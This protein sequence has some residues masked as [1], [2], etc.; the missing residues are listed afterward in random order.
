MVNIYILQLQRNKYYIGKTTNPNFRLDQHFNNQGSAWTKKY[1]PQ[2]IIK[3]IPNCSHYDEDKYTQI[4]M[5]KYGIYNVRGGS[6]CKVKLD[7]EEK[8]ILEKKSKGTQDKCF[9]CGR[10]NHFASSCPQKKKIYTIQCAICSKLFTEKEFERHACKIFHV[11]VN[12]CSKCGRDGHISI[13]CYAKKDVFGDY[14]SHSDDEEDLCS[15]C[16]R[17]NHDATECYAKKHIKGYR[18]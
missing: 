4:Y 15:R 5:D 10:D 1:K 17:D 7:P 2:R 9:Q 14:V 11:G 12:T 3:I 8:K 6:F 18:I 16:G 13:D